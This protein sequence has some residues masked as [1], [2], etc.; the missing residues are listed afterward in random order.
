MKCTRIIA[1]REYNLHG[2][3]ETV[4]TILI[5]ARRKRLCDYNDSCKRTESDRNFPSILPITEKAFSGGK[6]DQKKK[7]KTIDSVDFR[8][9]ELRVANGP[10]AGNSASFNVLRGQI[11]TFLPAENRNDLKTFCIRTRLI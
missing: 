11:G 5:A 10:P 9:F 6:K 2:P 8:T 7:K 3:C 1:Q 4:F